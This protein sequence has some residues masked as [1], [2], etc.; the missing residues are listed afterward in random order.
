MLRPYAF[1]ALVCVALPAALIAA[2]EPQPAGKETRTGKFQIHVPERCRDSAVPTL[3]ARMGWGNMD[4][5]KKSGWEQDYDLKNE[6]FEVYVPPDYTGKEPYGLIVWVNPGPTGNVHN[7]WVP[8]LDKHKLIWIGANNSGNNRS[9]W[10]RL[11][12][13][14]DAAK[15]MPTAYNVDKD[16]VYVSG[17]SGGGRCSSMLGIAYPEYFTGGSY[18]IIGCNFYR[19]VYVSAAGPNKAA[20]FY[21]QN[22]KRPAGKLWDVV[23]KE[24]RHVFLTG[25]NDGNRQ[26][27]ELNFKAAKGDGFR[28]ITYIQVPGMGHQSPNAE[29]FEKGINALDDGREAVA[30]GAAGADE[31]KTSGKAEVKAE[32]KAE[33]KAPPAPRPK[34][35][36]VAA[37]AQV[38]APE[39]NRALTPE[40]EAAKLM[41]LARLYLDNRLYTKA[42]EKLNQLVMD[43]P[44]SPEATEAQKLL[45]EL[46][47]K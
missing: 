21:Q 4:S 6:T 28:H 20:E 44:K 10:I 19:R 36:P 34:P 33:A 32:T 37:K 42:R 23:T 1:A 2:D 46:G 45:K 18:P 27:T 29:W 26:Q 40:E 16:R 41:K 31:P 13:A 12:M 30:K 5:V 39:E 35:E 7:D 47:K 3:V 25:D 43:Y 11:G 15:Y 9:S 38:P 22:F 17:A 14:L 8:V 24:R